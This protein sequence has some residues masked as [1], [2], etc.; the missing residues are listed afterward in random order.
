MSQGERKRIQ[1]GAALWRNPE[2]LT[3]DEPTNHMDL[4]SIEC[5]GSALAESVCALMLVSHD[6][7]FL[8]KLAS[9]RWRIECGPGGASCEL[10]I[11]LQYPD[12]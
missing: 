4:P 6:E 10:K 5:V 1:V 3:L 8:E 12:R 2:L 11:L 7:R 9:E